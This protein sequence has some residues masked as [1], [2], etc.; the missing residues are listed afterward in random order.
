MSGRAHRVILT[1]QDGEVD[2]MGTKINPPFPLWKKTLGWETRPKKFP[3]INLSSQKKRYLFLTVKIPRMV[4][5][6]W[7]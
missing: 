3:E 1:I 6:I 2:K 4:M 5:V 7:D